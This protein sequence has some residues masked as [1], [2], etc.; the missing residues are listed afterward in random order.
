MRSGMTSLVV[1]RLSARSAAD[2]DYAVAAVVV[3]R[4]VVVSASARSAA[5]GRWLYPR[6][7]VVAVIT[8]LTVGPQFT[9]PP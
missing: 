9:V 4:V 5:V 7:S 2:S 1:V 3:S 6:P 8:L